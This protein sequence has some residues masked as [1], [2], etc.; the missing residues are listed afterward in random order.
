MKKLSL[1]SFPLAEN[2]GTTEK[3]KESEETYSGQNTSVPPSY[4]LLQPVLL[5]ATAEE[6]STGSQLL[7][8]FCV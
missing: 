6:S 7:S 4:W 2:P 5:F 3:R 1:S 8:M